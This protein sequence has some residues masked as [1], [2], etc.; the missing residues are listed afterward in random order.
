M[1]RQVTGIEVSV[2]HVFQSTTVSMSDLMNLWIEQFT[3]VH[4]AGFLD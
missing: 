3:A 4:V 2:E 1:R